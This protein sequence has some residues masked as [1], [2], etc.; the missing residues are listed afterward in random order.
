MNKEWFKLEV[1]QDYSGEDDGESLRCWIRG[2]KQ[3]SIQ[4]MKEEL[5]PGELQDYHQKQAAGVKLT[6]IRMLN[7]PH[8]VYTAWE[9]EHYNHVN[10]P[11]YGEQIYLLENTE[12]LSLKLPGG[13]LMIF[14][15]E[16]AVLNSYSKNG[17][18]IN[19]TFYDQ[20]DDINEFIQL[21]KKLKSLAKPMT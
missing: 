6:R 4:L 2:E 14:D 8:S 1:L 15:N 20:A 5:D 7:S 18:V 16:R 10:I 12:A 11:L 19:Q 9:L 21:S 3:K 13:D 17:Q